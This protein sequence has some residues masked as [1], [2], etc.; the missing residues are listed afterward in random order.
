MA[1]EFRALDQIGAEVI[2][3]D[4]QRDVDSAT[5]RVLYDAWL[6]HGVLL[7]R[8]TG[9]GPKEHLKLSEVFGELE[10][11]PVVSSRVKGE[12]KLIQLPDEGSFKYIIDGHD[13]LG[14]LFWHQDTSYTPGICKGALLRMEVA[15]EARGQ[16]GWVDTHKAY[17]EMPA[18]LRSRI[19]R[20]EVR[21]SF[22]FDAALQKFGAGTMKASYAPGLTVADTP[23]F[24]L[25]SNFPPVIHPVVIEHPESG[26]KALTISPANVDCIVGMPRPESDALL[27]ELIEHV[28]QPQFRYV[29]QWNHGDMILWDNRRTLHQ[30]FGWSP[31]VKRRAFRTTLAGPFLCGR[32]AS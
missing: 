4:L 3:L 13:T 17:M 28:L 6:E 1:L 22:R 12:P 26:K 8:D 15:A 20:C 18:P 23:T 16:T 2:G 31:G 25:Q 11:H 24:Q 30:A 7:F 32:Y 14:F 29:H 19:E 10:E 21:M 5:R 9:A 27:A